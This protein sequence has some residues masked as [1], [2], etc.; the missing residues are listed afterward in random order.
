MATQAA[1][2][3]TTIVPIVMTFVPDPVKAGLVS[4]VARPGGNITGLTNVAAEIS[5]KRLE[6][7]KEAL[8]GVSRGA[9]LGFHRACP[10]AP[11]PDRRP[12]VAVL[13]FRPIQG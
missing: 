8:P 13:A 2:E 4:S 6:L 1:K 7:L 9:V 10:S 3:A 5:P 11:P 12:P